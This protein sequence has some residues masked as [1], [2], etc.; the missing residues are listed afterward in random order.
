MVQKVDQN[1]I[2]E[3]SKKNDI[4]YMST[5]AFTKYQIDELFDYIGGELYEYLEKK[6]KK[7]DEVS[8]SKGKVISQANLVKKKKKC[9]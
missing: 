2:D 1:L 8:A 3:L 9:C 7:K 6:P 5:S 4:L